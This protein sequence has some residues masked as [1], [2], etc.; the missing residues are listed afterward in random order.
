MSGSTA[1]L[2]FAMGAVK[3]VFDL[4]AYARN[5]VPTSDWLNGR[6]PPVFSD[7]AATVAAIALAGSGRVAALPRDEFVIVL[8]GALELRAGAGSISL[9][10]GESAVVPVGTTFDWQAAANTSAVIVSCPTASSAAT[11]IVA[12]NRDAPLSPS[13]PPLASLLVGPT[14]SCRNNTQFKSANGE[15]MCGTWDSTP[16]HRQPMPYRHIELMHLLEGRLTLED[17][18][19]SVTFETGAVLLCARGAQCAWISREHVKKVFA[20]HRPA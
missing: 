6:A 8:N 4:R 16:Y 13:N 18:D 15:F 14:P 11:G 12:M 2:E 19:G 9:S 7:A 1:C 17:S 5:A 10:A 3:N 20:I